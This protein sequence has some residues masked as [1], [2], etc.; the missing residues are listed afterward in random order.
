MSNA[1]KKSFLSRLFSRKSRRQDQSA[2]QDVPEWEGL[3]PEDLQR[4]TQRLDR[5]SDAYRRVYRQA[6]VL[7]VPL[8]YRLRSDRLQLPRPAHSRAIPI[9]QAADKLSL[10]ERDVLMRVLLAQ[11]SQLESLQFVHGAL[12]PASVQLHRDR[13]MWSASLGQF[14]SGRF[15]DEEAQTENR[16]E[17]P[18]MSPEG[19]QRLHYPLLDAAADANDAFSAGCMYYTILTGHAPEVVP[20]VYHPA[21]AVSTHLP[22]TL[23]EISGFRAALIRW[24]LSPIAGDR[25]TAREALGS[26]A[27]AEKAGLLKLPATHLQDGH[28]VQAEEFTFRQAPVSDLHS[29]AQRLGVSRSGSMHLVREH[30]ELWDPG[31]PGE[32]RLFLRQQATRQRALQR[33]G[34]VCN[35][36]QYWHSI[37]PLVCENTLYAAHTPPLTTAPLE[38]EALLMLQQLHELDDSIFLLDARMTDILFAMQTLHDDGYV[39]GCFT[40]SAFYAEVTQ[41]GAVVHLADLSGAAPVNDLPPPC[42]FS[43]DPRELKLLSPELSQYI[44]S[45]S[46]STDFDALL[47]VSTASDIFTLGLI[48]H[49]ILVGSY[50]Q[51][52]E[53]Q[54]G[55]F[56]NAL[57]HGDSPDSVFVIDPRI[58]RRHSRLIRSMLAL[59]PLKRPQR[60]DEIADSIMAFYTG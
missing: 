29:A 57:C 15:T 44:S 36:S 12:C 40:E 10:Q 33:I 16:F 8:S 53:P 56:C 49:L 38:G 41:H 21:Q 19:W 46:E 26:M 9:T 45:G 54:Y 32:D 60:C 37:R 42:D 6:S 25:P 55:T 31:D 58:D 13:A 18:W 17:S 28:T 7:D 30:D 23:P 20:G 24:M 2:Y 59:D 47:W 52:A 34:E 22:V 35:R 3:P 48:Y 11:L 1:Q 27:R 51:L 4:I 5:L 39:L 14:H 50:P 43:P